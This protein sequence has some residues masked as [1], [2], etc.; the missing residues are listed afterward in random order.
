MAQ[1]LRQRQPG[2][3]AADQRLGAS[4][5]DAAQPVIRL[6][7]IG[8][9]FGP[10]RANDDITLAIAPGEIVGLIGANGAG[11]STLMRT[12]C[13]LVRPDQ[14]SFAIEGEAIDLDR[15]SPNVALASGIR[16]VHQELSLCSNLTVSE[17]FMLEEPAPPLAMAT[18]W[19]SRFADRARHHT[20]EIFPGIGLHPNT[21]ISD[22]RIGQRQ[23]V[24]ISRAAGTESLKLLVLDE[25]TSSLDAGRSGNLRAWVRDR[26]ASGVAFIFI[27]HKLHE[28]LDFAGRVVIM[29][30]GRIIWDGPAAQTS[31][32][33]LVEQMGGHPLPAVQDAQTANLRLVDTTKTPLVTADRI[34][35]ARLTF[36]GGEIIGL[37]GLDG[38][39]QRPFLHAILRAGRGQRTSGIVCAAEPSFVSGDRRGE[40]VFPLWSVFENIVLGATVGR[41]LLGS[42]PRPRSAP[43][44][45]PGCGGCALPTRASVPTFWNSAAAT[46]RKRWPHVP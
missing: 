24:E 22:L 28:I 3:A 9:S 34:A 26:A 21:S 17:N 33:E 36:S 32:T 25:P 11:K 39:G 30:N 4:G 16:I 29:R 20:E 5:R 12:I 42:I 7:G 1:A 37:A 38:N 23:A 6:S 31:V 40:G 44:S 27:S 19:R 2:A 45:N 41:N 8:K 13:G 35:G 14:G 10:T 15:Y 18:G 46:S 43:Q